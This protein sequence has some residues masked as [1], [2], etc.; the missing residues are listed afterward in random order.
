LEAMNF[1]HGKAQIPWGNICF[2]SF[3]K[4]NHLVFFLYRLVTYHWKVIEETYKN[5]FN[6]NSYE[7][8]TI[9]QNFGCICS[10][11]NTVT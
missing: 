4:H 11:G 2:K 6:K 3:C 7:N 10:V 9:T 1:P 5:H 8:I